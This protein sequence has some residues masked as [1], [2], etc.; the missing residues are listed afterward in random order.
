MD[1]IDKLR[2][3]C[4]GSEIQIKNKGWRAHSIINA[5]HNLQVYLGQEYLVDGLN[6]MMKIRRIK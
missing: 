2:K 1:V 6:D 4:V 3:M 5:I